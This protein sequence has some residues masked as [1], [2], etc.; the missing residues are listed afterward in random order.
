MSAQRHLDRTLL[1]LRQMARMDAGGPQ[2]IAPVLRALQ[3]VIGFDS[4]GYLYRRSDGDLDMHMENPATRAVMPSYFEPSVLRSE[5]QVMQRSSRLFDEALRCERG[6][7][8][9]HDLVKVPVSELRRSDYYNA[10]LRPGEVEV[11]MKLPL[12]ARDGRGIGILWLYRRDGE[13]HFSGAD[14][15]ALGR[16][17]A[18]LARALQSADG[19]AQDAD[20]CGQGL[21]VVTP[22]GRPLWIEPGTEELLEQAFG[23]RWRGCCGE[24]P[25]DLQ[26]LV[27]RLFLPEADA[28]LPQLDF[29]N[30]YGRFSMRATH[31]TGRAGAG[32]AVA[33]HVTRR[34]SSGAR[35]LEQLRPLALPQRQ[36]ELAYWLARGLSEPQIAARMGISPNTVVY[37]RRQLYARMEVA[38]REKLLAA[39]G[40]APRAGMTPRW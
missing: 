2:Q 36:H 8:M 37:H 25:P 34:L 35:L 6:V 14:A 23:W 24:L 10:V 40:F 4:G 11:G 32:D 12:R 26:V 15:A 27:Q 20:V 17:E 38:N 13:R 28:P 1:Q 5:Q 21:L 22:M 9:Q 7:Q 30:A 33:I 29:R 19:D 16:L 18:H 3:G 39:L 31:L